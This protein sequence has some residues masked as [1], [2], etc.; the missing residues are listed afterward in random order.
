MNN[1]EREL[2]IDN[3]EGLYLWHRGSKLSKRQFIKEHR[4]EIDEIIDR[5]INPKKYSD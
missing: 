3:D 2:W 5:A 1:R 4:A